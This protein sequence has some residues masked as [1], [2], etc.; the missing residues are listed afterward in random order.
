MVIESAEMRLEKLA[1]TRATKCLQCQEK[2]WLDLAWVNKR[3]YSFGVF[4]TPVGEWSV[5]VRV[6]WRE[7][8]RLRRLVRQ[9][10]KYSN[11]EIMSQLS[12]WHI[13]VFTKQSWFAPIILV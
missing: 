10:L 8:L 13:L 5:N 6:E 11:Q 12:L 2:L 3:S 1:K 7:R 9:L 4:F